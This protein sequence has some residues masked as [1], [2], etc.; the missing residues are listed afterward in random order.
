MLFKAD[1]VSA[2]NITQRIR[3]V[4]SEIAKVPTRPAKQGMNYEYVSHDDVARVIHPLLV[5]WGIVV[6]PAMLK[7]DTKQ[8]SYQKANGE[9]VKTFLTDVII[10]VSFINA[11]NKEDHITM[12]MP[13]LG[14]DPMDKGAGKAVSYA[15]KY[16][17]IKLFQLEAGEPDVDEIQTTDAMERQRSTQGAPGKISEKQL[18][19]VKDMIQRLGSES[20]ASEILKR[21]SITKVDENLPYGKAKEL[22]EVLKSL[23][24]KKG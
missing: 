3:G 21:M 17:I 20:Q 22:I 14:M 6:V 2:L 13:G 5:K 7:A 16:A 8:V 1:D 10:Q 19:Y 24:D 4:M 11:D 23:T 15:I 12:N 18:K 9:D